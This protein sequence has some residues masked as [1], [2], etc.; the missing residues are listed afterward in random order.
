LIYICDEQNQR[1]QIVDKE[2]GRFF[3]PWGKKEEKIFVYPQSIYYERKECLFYIGDDYNVQ[4]WDKKGHCIERLGDNQRGG[5]LDYQLDTVCGISIMGN[6]LYVGDSENK[7]IQMFSLNS[8][9]LR[10]SRHCSDQVLVS[11]H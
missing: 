8:L 4:I 7:R 6:N 11:I 2:K 1:I 9:E 3:S 5:S 10:E